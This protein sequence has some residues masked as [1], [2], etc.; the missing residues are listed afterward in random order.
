MLAALIL[1]VAFFYCLLSPVMQDVVVLSAVA[2]FQSSLTFA[3]KAGAYP[4]EAL[5]RIPYSLG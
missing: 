1:G 4:S 2:P 5:S 3:S